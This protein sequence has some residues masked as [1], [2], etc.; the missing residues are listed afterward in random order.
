MVYHQA[1][2]P[3]VK[4]I[5]RYRDPSERRYWFD[6]GQYPIIQLAY[7][8]GRWHKVRTLYVM[9]MAYY[10]DIKLSPNEKYL[11]ILVENLYLIDLSK[12][13]ARRRQRLITQPYSVFY[14]SFS[15]DSQWLLGFNP[16]KGILALFNLSTGTRQI[17]SRG[18]C[19]GGWYPDGQKIWYRCE[20]ESVVYE[21]DIA[22]ARRRPLPL[23]ELAKSWE[24]YDP[25]LHISHDFRNLSFGYP[26]ELQRRFAYSRDRGVR[27][28]VEPSMV[29]NRDA[30]AGEQALY[31]EWREGRRLPVWQQGKHRYEDIFPLD[32]TN[33]GR[34]A[35]VSAEIEEKSKKVI[36]ALNTSTREEVVLIQ[37]L[38]NHAY[39]LIPE[40][41]SFSSNLSWSPISIVFSS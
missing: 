36:L 13:L 26:V 37:T 15:P 23:D 24:L 25:R 29:G 12:P 6:G 27:I 33:D 3:P 21:H 8:D 34:W 28:V 17:V 40:P 30:P 18:W 10:R 39:Q 2:V 11:L 7:H 1:W 9:G 19:C 4:L 20:R 38:P 14:A 32:V 5:L 31:V 16:P 35:I 41:P 22:T